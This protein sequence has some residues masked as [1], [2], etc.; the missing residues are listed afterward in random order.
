MGSVPK[1]IPYTYPYIRRTVP[2]M[3]AGH[4]LSSGLVLLGVTPRMLIV[5]P[6]TFQQ[7]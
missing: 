3:L 5:P 2:H 7:P 1:H 6:D 4:G